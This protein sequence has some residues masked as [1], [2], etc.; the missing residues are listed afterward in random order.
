[1]FIRWQGDANLCEGVCCLAPEVGDKRASLGDKMP[2]ARHLEPTFL[3]T[4]VQ[5][6]LCEVAS[7]DTDAVGG[8]FLMSSSLQIFFLCYFIF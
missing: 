5:A 2:L 1:M 4:K 6:C 3:P 8:C 7:F